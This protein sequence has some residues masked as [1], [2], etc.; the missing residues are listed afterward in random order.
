MFRSIPTGWFPTTSLMFQM[1]GGRLLMSSW[2]QP[3]RFERAL[4]TS[5]VHPTSDLPLRDRTSPRGQDPRFWTCLVQFS[6]YW[7]ALLTD[8]MDG[9]AQSRRGRDLLSARKLIIIAGQA[10][11]MTH[12]CPLPGGTP[13]SSDGVLLPVRLWNENMIRTILSLATAAA[14]LAVLLGTP[15]TATARQAWA[16][17]WC[18]N[19]SG[20]LSADRRIKGCT[21]ILQTG[22]LTGKALAWIFT[23]RGSAYEDKGEYDRAIADFGQA[24]EFDPASACAFHNR[25]IAYFNKED[26]VHAI[27]DYD[28]AIRLNPKCE[29][30]FV[31]RGSAYFHLGDKDHALSDYDQAIK[32]NPKS[33]DAHLGLGVVYDAER[34]FDRA[35]AEYTRAIELSPRYALAFINRGSVYASRKPQFDKTDWSLAADDWSQAIR[36]ETKQFP[37]F[38]A[39]DNRC[40]A[41]AKMGQLQNALADC[42]A[43][44]RLR[45]DY[46]DTL[47]N[48]GLAYLRLGRP[49]LA[50]ADYDAALTINPKLA[51]ALYGRGLAKRDKGETAGAE[52]D[53][54]AATAIQPDIAEA[55]ARYGLK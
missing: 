46:D 14:A 26:Y 24:I 16:A 50:V 10:M 37:A 25:G 1:H 22:R 12:A 28:Q 32:L 38:A 44:L 31:D 9:N 33:A 21:A 18:L 43:S 13:L 30:V 7:R 49:D 17:T 39:F 29:N 34:E 47:K 35:I 40:E 19:T 41:R 20:T 52:A 8:I 23:S 27:S 42:N 53:V 45:P 51:E 4:G 48:R 2:G 15:S 55:S 5:G 36:F 3:R 6:Q 11:L 54:A